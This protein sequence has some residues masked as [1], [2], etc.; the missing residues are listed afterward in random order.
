MEPH[1]DQG[2]GIASANQ[3]AA[4]VFFVSKVSCGGSMPIGTKKPLT[5]SG[6]KDL[7]PTI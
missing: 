4:L 6:N 1:G 2:D 3:P 7:T 5:R